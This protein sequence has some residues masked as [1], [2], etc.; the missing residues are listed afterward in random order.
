MKVIHRYWATIAAIYL[1]TFTNLVLLVATQDRRFA[2]L[3]FGVPIFLAASL[4]FLRC[5]N[6]RQSMSGW[7]I[8]RNGI[9]KK[10]TY[11]STP[12]DLR[13]LNCGFKLSDEDD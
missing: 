2:F 3:F 10:S 1:I 9:Q 13:C 12:L 8:G 4:L 7:K 11:Y 5:P 6:C